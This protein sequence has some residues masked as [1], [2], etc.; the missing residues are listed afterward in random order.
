MPS[1][2]V[3]YSNIPYAEDLP[4]A[5]DGKNRNE[6][7]RTIFEPYVPFQRKYAHYEKQTLVS[8]MSKLVR[9]SVNVIPQH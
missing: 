7:I 3:C 5:V 4:Y 1:F 2:L 8:K 9:Y 6:V